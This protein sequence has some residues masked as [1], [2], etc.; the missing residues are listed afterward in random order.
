MGLCISRQKRCKNYRSFYCTPVQIVVIYIKQVCKF[1]HRGGA[2]AEVEV[3]DVVVE[4][5]EAGK[6]ATILL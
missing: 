6:Y 2:P 5:A 4:C 1:M 3:P